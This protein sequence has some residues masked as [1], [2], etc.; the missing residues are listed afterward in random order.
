M[1]EVITNT[2]FV[3]E[4]VVNSSDKNYKSLFIIKNIELLKTLMYNN[5]VLVEGLGLKFNDI[6]KNRTF[7]KQ[8]T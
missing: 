2:C 8:K 7:Y 4:W 3:E 1:E 6:V 5:N